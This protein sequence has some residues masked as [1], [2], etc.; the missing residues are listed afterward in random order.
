MRDIQPIKKQV[1]KII[2]DT[3]KFLMR[4]EESGEELW[5]GEGTPYPDMQYVSTYVI[6]LSE[7]THN[8]SFT[9]ALQMMHNEKSSTHRGDALATALCL[10]QVARGN[11]IW[12][13]LRIVFKDIIDEAIDMIEVVNPEVIG[14]CALLQFQ[15]DLEIMDEE[16][17]MYES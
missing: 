11:T 12:N 1:P 8:V 5:D 14:P 16:D 10:L 9:F 6:H 15:E 17:E 3:E 7:W 4:V 2:L 13:A